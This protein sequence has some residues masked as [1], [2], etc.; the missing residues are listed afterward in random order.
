[1]RRSE[2]IGAF[3]VVLLLSSFGLVVIAQQEAWLWIFVK[4]S[5]TQ[6]PIAGAM[7]YFD[8][9]SCGSTDN[10]GRIKCT[11]T[12]VN[13][14]E[15]HSWRV[16]KSGYKMQQG[17]VL[18]ENFESGGGLPVYLES[19]GPS[20]KEAWLWLFVKDAQTQSPI[21]GATV[22]FDGK[23]MPQTDNDGKSDC[24]YVVV[25]P[26]ETHS[27]RVE[28][29]GYKMQQGTVLIENFE[30]GGGLPVYLQREAPPSNP[31]DLTLYQPEINGLT[32]A[33]NG[34]ATPGTVGA[35]ITRIHWDWGDGNS[36]DYWF[37]AS[38]TYGS[39]GTYQITATAY[40]SDGLST[41]RSVTV[42]VSGGLERAQITNKGSTSDYPRTGVQGQTFSCTVRWK[43]YHWAGLNVYLSDMDTGQPIASEQVP[44]GAGSYAHTFSVVAPNKESWTLGVEIG[45]CCDPPEDSYQWTVALSGGQERRPPN[46]DLST[47]EVDG[48]RVRVNGVTTPGTPSATVDRIRWDWGDGHSEDYWFPASHTYGS[49]GTYQI[50]ATAYQ[51]DGLSSTKSVT[52]VVSGGQPPPSQYSMR[53]INVDYPPKVD[54][55]QDFSVTVEIEYSFGEPT[56]TQTSI[57]DS[58][59]NRGLK[60][61]E[62]TLSGSGTKSYSFSVTAHSSPGTWHLKAHV[63]YWQDSSFV[64]DSYQPDLNITVAGTGPPELSLGTPE[65]DGLS[66][67]I[68]GSAIPGTSD[69]RITR[70]HLDW[71]DGSSTDYSSFAVTH[72][73]RQGGKYS[74]AV[75]AYQSDELTTLKYTSVDLVDADFGD[76]S[77]AIMPDLGIRV[78]TINTGETRI[79]RFL[80]AP[81][82]LQTR[83]TLIFRDSAW[84]G[85]RYDIDVYDLHAGKIKSASGNSGVW[86]VYL[87]IRIPD[88]PAAP[89]ADLEVHIHCVFRLGGG[90]QIIY[91]EGGGSDSWIASSRNVFAHGEPLWTTTD[92]M[93]TMRVPVTY[94]SYGTLGIR[95]KPYQ[96]E[97]SSRRA[98]SLL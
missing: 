14:P 67:R 68:D 3:V 92:I 35:S 65:V 18:I 59:A 95:T 79:F 53:I 16:E 40:Q 82:G 26:P 21:A 34:V 93:P 61:T 96:H 10:E 63:G 31:P 56:R 69:A 36:E 9:H 58:D 29:S 45:T 39:G 17:T 19:E 77:G 47:P 44:A 4:D 12:V 87:D 52:V 64:S 7:V 23:L 76:I 70:I 37:P 91:Y 28:K 57:F 72:T 38:H 27:W 8:G 88:I 85:G 71:G 42:T 83:I 86:L 22:Y 97:N 30:S 33:I 90:E 24:S 81:A 48:L 1:M 41:T 98:L 32:V 43:Q 5:Q 78:P 89:S 6:A 25:N 60:S 94:D 11:Y 54:I 15:T 55:N 13:P 51:S 73:Y 74:I 49:G 80:I 50:T 2:L 84:P 62:E 75:T 20:P 46:L 66:I